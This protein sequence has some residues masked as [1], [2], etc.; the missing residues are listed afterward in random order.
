MQYTRTALI[1]DG[2]LIEFLVEENQQQSVVG[3]I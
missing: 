3:N 1:E 2:D